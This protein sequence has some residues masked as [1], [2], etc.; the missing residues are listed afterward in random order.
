MKASD[1]L[2]KAAQVIQEDMENFPNRAH[3]R[4]CCD[5]IDRSRSLPISWKVFFTVARAEEYL[6]SLYENDRAYWFGSPAET[7]NQE[8]RIIALLLTADMAESVG[9]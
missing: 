8:H 6:R 1:V 7:E 5:A 9:D 2:R 4:G 3:W